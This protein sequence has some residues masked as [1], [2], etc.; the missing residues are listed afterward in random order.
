MPCAI[1]LSPSA[2]M[3]LYTCGW[4][5]VSLGT[6]ECLGNL[7]LLLPTLILA[8]KLFCVTNVSILRAD[9]PRGEMTCS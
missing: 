8:F 5:C 6:R 4:V 1:E 7:A 2:V 3:H 9:T